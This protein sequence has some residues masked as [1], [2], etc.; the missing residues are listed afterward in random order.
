[1]IELLPW[2][3]EVSFLR[4][5]SGVTEYTPDKEPYI[6][7]LPGVPGYFTACGFSGQGFCLGPMVGKV[8]SEL[9][10]GREPSVSLE[11]FKPDRF[12]TNQ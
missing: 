5:F 6:G 2:L 8:I 12:A 11:P 9:V 7:T 1:M 3:G 10:T 4:A